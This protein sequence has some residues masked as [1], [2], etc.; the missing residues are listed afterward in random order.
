VEKPIHRVSSLFGSTFTSTT[1]QV[2]LQQVTL[3]RVQKDIAT[4]T[5]QINTVTD[6]L[7]TL[8]GNIG[9]VNNELIDSHSRTAQLE[10]RYLELKAD[11]DLLNKPKPIPK[12]MGIK[13]PAVPEKPPAIVTLNSIRVQ[14]DATWVSLRDGV[15]SSPLLTLGDEWHGAT[16]V[17]AD[18]IKKEAQLLLNGISTRVKL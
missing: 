10:N 2:E 16:L 7:A 1:A 5:T 15:E 8:K 11:I 13:K 12:P 14:G 18:P 17:T 3:V 9:D 6:F 4:L